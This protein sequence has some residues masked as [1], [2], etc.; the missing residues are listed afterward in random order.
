VY[1]VMCRCVCHINVRYTD[2]CSSTL[3]TMTK[4]METM[5]MTIL[6]N[7]SENDEAEE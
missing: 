6:I 5:A 4:Q 3:S 7:K 1:P 2:W